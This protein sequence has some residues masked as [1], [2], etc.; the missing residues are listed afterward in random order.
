[1]SVPAARARPGATRGRSWRQ[2][3]EGRRARILA[4]ATREFARRGYRA[5]RLADVAKAADVA[6]GTVFHLFGSK[7]ELLRAVGERYGRGLA[8]AA[9]FVYGLAPLVESIEPVQKL[10][11]FWWYLGA[12]PLNEGFDMLFVL[13]LV[14]IA[15]GVAAALWG[16]R[17]RDVSV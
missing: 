10:S 12:K 9:F 1:M 11:P 6:E 8:T 16:F 4:A 14:W 17:R 5:A 7:R 3:P 13:M 15:A 2:D